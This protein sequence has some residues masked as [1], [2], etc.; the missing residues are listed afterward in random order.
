MPLNFSKI[1]DGC[2]RTADAVTEGGGALGTIPPSSFGRIKRGFKGFLNC[3]RGIEGRIKCEFS[4]RTVG[5]LFYEITVTKKNTNSEI[6]T[7]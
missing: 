1:N 4:T 3:N 5:Q 2:S 7:T 6:N